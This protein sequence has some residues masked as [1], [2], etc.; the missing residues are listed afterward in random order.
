MRSH[1]QCGLAFC[2]ERSWQ[3]KGY[4]AGEN[5]ADSDKKI[6]IAIGGVRWLEKENGR[7]VN[8]LTSTPVELAPD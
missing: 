4:L 3:A 7:S 8:K 2:G 6:E 5:L 1:T